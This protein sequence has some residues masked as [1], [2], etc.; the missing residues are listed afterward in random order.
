MALSARGL[1]GAAALQ[2]P[3]EGRS[4]IG[5]TV[6]PSVLPHIHY[7]AD[8]LGFRSSSDFFRA[9][10][11]H[12]AR[13]QRRRLTDAAGLQSLAE[14]VTIADEISGR[15]ASR[16][17]TDSRCRQRSALHKMEAS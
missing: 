13:D 14:L 10:I 17:V 6:R 1:V 16:R 8:L 9:A 12:F 4:Y 15:R 5:A 2:P 7:V 11:A 3:P